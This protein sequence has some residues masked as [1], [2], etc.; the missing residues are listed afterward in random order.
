M[1]ETLL[2]I[3]LLGVVV[4]LGAGLYELFLQRELRLHRGTPSE[5]AIARVYTR[6]GPVIAAATVLVAVT[7]VLQSSLLGWGYFQYFWLGLKQGLMRLVLI[8]VG[9][10][11]P[12]FIRLGRV[13]GALLDGAS[14][15]P[16]EGRRLFARVEPWVLVMRA[17]GLLAVI[18]AVFRPVLD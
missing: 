7:G 13:V 9:A 18:L 6:Y 16:E 2:T 3:H 10:L 17:A 4:W 12:S 14:E 11:L 8:L 15:L 5:V 1:R